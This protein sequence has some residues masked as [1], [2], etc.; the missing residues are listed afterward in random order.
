MTSASPGLDREPVTNADELAGFD[1]AEILEGYM[2][3][4]AGD[5]EPGG[6]RS[7][8]YWHGWRNGS[9][10]RAGKVDDAQRALISSIRASQA[11]AAGDGS[12]A[13]TP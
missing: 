10:D 12:K 8:G 4:L 7:K 9:N 11:L 3:A 2:D 13:G 1:D 6:N 5:G